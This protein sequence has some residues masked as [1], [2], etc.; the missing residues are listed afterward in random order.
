M[1]KY[2]VEVLLV[3]IFSCWLIGAL[4]IL[5][6]STLY[7]LYCLR[8]SSLILWVA[9]A[10]LKV[11]LDALFNLHIVHLIYFS[12]LLLL[13]IPSKN[14]L[15]NPVS[16]KL[17]PVCSSSV[18][19]ILALFWSVSDPFW[20]NFIPHINPV[21]VCYLHVDVP[22]S[23][24]NLLKRLGKKVLNKN[25]KVGSQHKAGAASTHARLIALPTNAST[26]VSQLTLYSS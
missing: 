16:M 22:F 24:Y 13:L 4:D 7:R 11:S 10:V 3:L 18:F 20:F 23:R 14:L 1:D 2:I 8:V 17:C 19:I 5:G 25:K 26:F 6:M 12:L 9:F 21:Q 15:P